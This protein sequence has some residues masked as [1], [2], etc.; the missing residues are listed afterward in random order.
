MDAFK[1]R[2]EERKLKE[3][4]KKGLF[5]GNI[6]IVKDFPAT[7]SFNI[8]GTSESNADET[9]A[10]VVKLLGGFGDLSNVKGDFV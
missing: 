7:L 2:M 1:Q 3:V 6:P 9:L 5:A 10:L 4:Q 8:L